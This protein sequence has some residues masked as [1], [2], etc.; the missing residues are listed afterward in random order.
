MAL[1]FLTAEKHYRVHPQLAQEYHI[2][3]AALAAVGYAKVH[4][5]LLPQ[6]TDETFVSRV[7]M[8]HG[9]WVV[10]CPFCNSSGVAS[11]NDER[12]L[13][14]D[15]LNMEIGGAYILAPFPKDCEA[16]E[17]HMLLRPRNRRNWNPDTETL[18]N[19]QQETEALLPL[20]KEVMSHPEGLR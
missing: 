19:L 10:D 16:V 6:K 3:G 14:G 4:P 9:R 1:K 12:F 13:C 2:P 18:K 7:Y 17:A 20:E 5:E 11:E 15:C 8:N